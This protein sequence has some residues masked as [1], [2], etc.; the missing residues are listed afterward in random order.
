VVLATLWYIS[1][2]ASFVT[3][4]SVVENRS[5]KERGSR[6]VPCLQALRREIRPRRSWLIF[7]A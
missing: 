4:T 5:S 3:L 7:P 6:H 1:T 2:N